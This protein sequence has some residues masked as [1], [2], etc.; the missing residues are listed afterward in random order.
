MKSITASLA[1][2]L[3]TAGSL[4]A[5]GV[6]SKLP[7]PDGKPADMSK[8]VKVYILAGQSNMVGFGQLDGAQ[9]VYPSIFLSADPGIKAG[10]MPVGPS[11]LLPHG[12]YQSAARDAPAGAKVAIYAGAYRGDAVYASM[13]PVKETTVALGTVEAPL[14]AIDGPHTVVAEAFLD[15]PMT[16]AYEL[17][18]GHEDSSYA[19]AALNG[20]EIY[21][22]EIGED[23]V[24]TKVT[25]E[26]GKRYPI[27]ITYRQGGSAALWM[28]LVDVQGKGDLRSLTGQGRF[29]WFVDEDGNWTTRQ[30]VT[31]VDTRLHP[32][33]GGRPLSPTVNTTGRHIGPEIPF[34]YVMGTYHDEHV[35]LIKSSI[36]NRALSFDFRPPSSGK[37]EE[38][39]DNEWCGKEYDLL[40][41]GVHDTLR[42]IDTIVPGYR[43]QGYEIAGFVWWQGH[44][45]S[46]LSKEEYE[47]H[48]VNLIRDLRKEFKAPKMRVAVATVAFGGDEVLEGPWKGVWEA[49]MAV[50]D[51]EQHPDFVGTIASVDARSFWRSPGESPTGTGFHYNHNAETYALTG[52]ALGRAMVEL[53]GGKAEK[54]D[55]PP[56]PKLDP[57]VD[58]VYSEE[59]TGQFNRRGPHYDPAYYREM[60]TALKP[61]VLGGL[62]PGFLQQQFDPERPGALTGIVRGDRPSRMPMDIRSPL[63]E[64]VEYYDVAGMPDYGWRPFAPQ[65]KGAN[66]FYY[67]FEPPE[68]QPLEKSDRY[69]QISFPDGMENWYAVDFDAVK[70]G[71]KEGAAPFGRMGDKR[72]ALRPR[73]SGTHCGC[74]SEPA[75]FWEHEVLLMRQT[76]DLPPVKDGHVYRLI[77]GGAGCDRSGEGFAIYVNGKQLVQQDGGFFR[78]TGIRGAYVY[79]DFLPAFKGGKVTIAIINFLRYTHFRNVTTYF[80]PHPDYYAKPVPPN[81]HVDLWMEEVKLSP[82]VLEAA[83]E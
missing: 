48:L 62:I 80:G 33:R 42:N 28:K 74:S 58:L 11:A 66:W 68:K 65:L 38:E 69:R 5:G 49:Q 3:M 17:Y 36:G 73:C 63:D 16:G 67:S 64:L 4:L 47:R 70:A 10:R 22:K 29:P 44:K 54:L 53:L 32:E 12:I 75:T 40:V 77:L 59:V 35:L 37:T 45:D 30:D 18:V 50:G 55:V 26:R 46:G 82:A 8:P 72:E 6:P 21:R 24:V 20:Q 79:D 71:W 39:K 34:G 9:P 41:T 14:P 56:A 52:D 57:N 61:M 15:V 83:G 81:G 1:V 27:R 51:P 13:K 60:G 31:Y 23:A 19:V 76:F 25:L 7:R 78:H 43:G 2:A